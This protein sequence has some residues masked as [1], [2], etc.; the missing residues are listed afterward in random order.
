MQVYILH[1]TWWGERNI[2]YEN[3]EKRRKKERGKGI[4]KKRNKREKREVREKEVKGAKTYPSSSTHH[5]K[6]GKKGGNISM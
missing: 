3:N 2:Q 6:L 1:S 5:K 4:R